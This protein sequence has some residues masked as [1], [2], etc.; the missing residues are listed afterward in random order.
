MVQI[1][2][3]IIGDGATDR[4]IFK[5]IV[6]VILADKNN[7]L[8]IYE[9]RRQSIHDAV[10]RYWQTATKSQQYYLPHP[11]ALDLQNAVIN[12]LRGGFADFEAEIGVGYTSNRD[13]LLITT[14]VEKKL[15]NPKDYFQEWAFSISKIFLGGIEKFYDLQISQGYN[16]EIIPVIMPIVTFPSTE[17]FVAA[18]RNIVN[19]KSYGK[20]PEEL[21]KILYGTT[22]LAT[23]NQETLQTQALNFITS[24]TIHKIF[25]CVPESRIFLQIL[26]L[27]KINSNS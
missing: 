14:D 11:A 13:I 15:T 22:N 18:A 26:S 20:K 12:V 21:K 17:I 16:Y 3:G 9:L 27:G 10:D 5:R 7:H 25:E 24:D 6:E 8:K 23:I 1:N 4:A 2:I 19:S